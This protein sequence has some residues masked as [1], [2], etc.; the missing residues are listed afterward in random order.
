[1]YINS[2]TIEGFFRN[3]GNGLSSV[4]R[5]WGGYDSIADK[6]VNIP[7]HAF[8]EVHKRYL[9]VEN[10]FNV[11]THADAWTN[12]ILFRYNEQNALVD[13]R[14]VRQKIVYGLIFRHKYD[15]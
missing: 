10:G 8:D 5:K 14:W 15:R 9:P 1:M 3:L 2:K 6:F 4:L 13:T 12:N 7:Q 11:L